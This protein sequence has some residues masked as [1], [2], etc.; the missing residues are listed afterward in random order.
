MITFDSI[1]ETFVTFNA[2]EDLDA[3]VVCKVTGDCAVGPCA[4]GDDFCGVARTVRC[5][6]AGVVLSGYCRIP[7]SGTAPAVGKTALCADGNGGVKAG[8]DTEYLVVQVDTAEKT[9]G[10]FL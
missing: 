4:A 2:E 9:V 8:G 6:L 5:G 7:Y 1:H 10:L 3:G